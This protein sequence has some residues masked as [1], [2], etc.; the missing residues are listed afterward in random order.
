ML[1]RTIKQDYIY[2]MA[3]GCLVYGRAWWDFV[4]FD[5][6]LPENLQFFTQRFTREEL[7]IQ[8]VLDGVIKFLDELDTL[9]A[10]IRAWK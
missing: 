10:K 6:R 3:G 8:E 2:Q 9:E 1:N 5:P 7:P 4:S